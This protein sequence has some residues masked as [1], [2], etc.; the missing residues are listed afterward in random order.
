MTAAQSQSEGKGKGK[1]KGPKTPAATPVVSEV[2][3]GA[4]GPLQRFPFVEDQS[5]YEEEERE[6][7]MAKAVVIHGVSTNWRINGVAD[8]AG[9]IMGEV[10]GVRWLLSEGRR[11]RKAASS[12]VVYLQ[13]EV[14]LGPEAC[15]KMSGKR[16][17]VV[18]Y[19]WKA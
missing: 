15:M 6:G 3:G 16:H 18:A 5:E 7:M 10:I 13:N 19:R 12:V 11:I 14:F 4:A 9:R 17:S 8:C 2:P 1:G